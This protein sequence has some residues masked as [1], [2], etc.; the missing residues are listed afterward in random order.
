MCCRWSHS[1]YPRSSPCSRLARTFHQLL[2]L[3]ASCSTGRSGRFFGSKGLHCSRLSLAQQFQLF[4][5]LLPGSP[6]RD[7]RNIAGLEVAL[8][9]DQYLPQ[10]KVA[11]TMKIYAKFSSLCLILFSAGPRWVSH[12]R[13]ISCPCYNSKYNCKLLYYFIVC[14][15]PRHT[16]KCLKTITNM[17]HKIGSYIFCSEDQFWSIQ[18]YQYLAS[19]PLPLSW[20]KMILL[21][22]SNPFMASAKIWWSSP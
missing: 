2:L 8:H 3:I 16:N 7:D 1:G 18:N 12:L 5:Q 6:G 17:K 15:S 20:F 11:M 22:N 19:G 10:Q 21:K 13:Q 9:P 4:A 14:G